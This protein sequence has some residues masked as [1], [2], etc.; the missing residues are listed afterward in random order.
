V[1]LPDGDTI[2]V[3]MSRHELDERGIETGDR[4]LLDLRGVRVSPRLNY[5]I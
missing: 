4:V 2:T 1:V 5:V 3:Q